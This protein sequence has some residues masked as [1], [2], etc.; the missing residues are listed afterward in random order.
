MALF[1]ASAD[2]FPQRRALTA[3]PRSRLHRVQSGQ[4]CS[5]DPACGTAAHVTTP[6]NSR[7]IRTIRMTCRDLLRT[8]P[9]GYNRTPVM[10]LD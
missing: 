8:T 1:G 4:P 9:A 3:R 7:S 6:V 10:R 5:R 2:Q